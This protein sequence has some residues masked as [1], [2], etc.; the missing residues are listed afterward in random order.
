MIWFYR[1]QEYWK[2]NKDLL[3]KVIH[4]FLESKNNSQVGFTNSFTASQ[5]RYTYHQE[6]VV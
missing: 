3:I 4:L 1:L 5:H 6:I 2:Q